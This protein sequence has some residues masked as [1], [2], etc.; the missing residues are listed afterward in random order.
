MIVYH[1]AQA[2]ALIE[3]EKE[4]RQRGYNITYADYLWCEHVAYG[5]TVKYD[6]PLTR[7]D[8]RNTKK[9]IHIQLYRMDKGT[10]EL[11]C[12]IL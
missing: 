6:F 7:I 11:N 8:G 10:Y 3:A 2:S 1:T 5:H 4:A 12:F 9:W